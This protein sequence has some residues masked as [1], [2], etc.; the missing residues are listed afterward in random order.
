MKFE[1]VKGRYTGKKATSVIEHADEGIGYIIIEKGKDKN[2]AF[3]IAAF[4][5]ALDS[6]RPH[7]LEELS[8][9]ELRKVEAAWDR[10][11][12]PETVKKRTDAENKTIFETIQKVKKQRGWG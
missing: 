4:R 12:K 10:R 6:P 5:R 7:H 9:Y 2:E 3:V 11:H 1:W 8:E